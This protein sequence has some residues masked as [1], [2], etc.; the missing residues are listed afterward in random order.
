MTKTVTSNGTVLSSSSSNSSS[1]SR[2]G[3]VGKPNVVFVEY[4][5]LSGFHVTVG[6]EVISCVVDSS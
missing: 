3:F 1:S 2:S 4:N 6:D 5:S